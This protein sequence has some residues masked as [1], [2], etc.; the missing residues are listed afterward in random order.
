LVIGV[1]F[2][3]EDCLINIER[4]SRQLIRPTFNTNQT[5]HQSPETRVRTN[6][7]CP[8]RSGPPIL[9]STG[10]YQDAYRY[11]STSAPRTIMERF[12][13]RTSPERTNPPTRSI[14]IQQGH[15]FGH[16]F[17]FL[18]GQVLAVRGQEEHSI[19]R[20]PP[21]IPAHRFI[22]SIGFATLFPFAALCHDLCLCPRE[23]VFSDG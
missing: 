20:I 6:L 17:Y 5:N 2:D 23:W 18:N 3:D 9:S 21:I 14:T 1:W 22:Q 11:C 12:Q 8:L 16:F 4:G 19:C 7:H 10:N 15:T 13:E